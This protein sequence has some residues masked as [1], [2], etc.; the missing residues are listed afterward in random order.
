MPTCPQCGKRIEYLVNVAEGL[1]IYHFFG[2]SDYEFKEVTDTRNEVYACPYCGYVVAESEDEANEFFSSGRVFVEEGSEDDKI[3]WKRWI[4]ALREAVKRL[5]YV[6]RMKGYRL[7][8][9]W[10]EDGTISS[11]QLFN[12]KTDGYI[13]FAKLD[14][15][16]PKDLTTIKMPEGN[17]QLLMRQAVGLDILAQ[18]L[19]AKG[20][21]ISDVV[22]AK[23]IAKLLLIGDLDRVDW[24]EQAKAAR[25]ALEHGLQLKCLG[26][27]ISEKEI[28]D[29]VVEQYLKT[30]L[31]TYGKEDL[32]RDL[33]AS[34]TLKR[35]ALIR[36]LFKDQ[37]Q[38]LVRTLE[39]E[40][41]DKE[42]EIIQRTLSNMKNPIRKAEI[43]NILLEKLAD[44]KLSKDSAD[45]LLRILDEYF[46]SASSS[47]LAK[48]LKTFLDEASPKYVQNPKCREAIL[49]LFSR[50]TGAQV[51]EI[52]LDK[53]SILTM[54]SEGIE[55]EITYNT[56]HFL[57]KYFV[58]VSLPK[59]GIISSV[60]RIATI[61]ADAKY[62]ITPQHI[63]LTRHLVMSIQQYYEKAV[64]ILKQM[65][66]KDEILRLFVK[67]KAL[68]KDVAIN[69]PF[70]GSFYVYDEKDFEKTRKVVDK[71]IG[72]CLNKL[73]EE[74]QKLGHDNL[75]RLTVDS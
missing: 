13:E 16:L 17:V 66:S 26:G 70:M 55:I 35:S 20:L 57:E 33:S 30:Y 8:V 74:I 61:E 4:E 21:M 42:F 60:G 27:F 19:S 68:Q 3:L 7:K 15:I 25:I 10:N 53:R 50:I 18:E 49:K 11:I 69:L 36:K 73:K 32:A 23:N 72:E 51:S 58:G 6:C 71:T 43:I 41:S 2:G 45:K 62:G 31:K 12:H 65:L 54:T 22:A 39:G 28:H 9:E 56:K 34:Y 63:D 59:I 40:V 47:D 37:L 67:M 5:E 24:R 46:L 75:R 64:K 38:L 48:I 52:K 44:E 14:Q 1:A 29:N